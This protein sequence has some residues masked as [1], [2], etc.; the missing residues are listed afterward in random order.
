M[1]FTLQIMLC[2]TAKSKPKLDS[3]STNRKQ[4][5]QTQMENFSVSKPLTHPVH[6]TKFV[7]WWIQE[8]TPRAP[9][10]PS[11]DQHLSI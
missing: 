2:K 5:R 8:E 4:F 10:C 11:T 1:N 7:H 3:G 6:V 9:P